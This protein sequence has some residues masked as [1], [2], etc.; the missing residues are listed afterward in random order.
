MSVKTHPIPEDRFGDYVAELNSI[1]SG[2]DLPHAACC[3]FLLGSGARIG[4]ALTVR[5]KDLFAADGSPLER[6]TRS[7]E[8]KRQ[9]DHRLTVTFPWEYLGAPLIAWRRWVQRHR[10]A[11]PDDYL[12][13]VGWSGRPLSRYSLR[14]G[15]VRILRRLGIPP[16]GVGL[17][18]IR[19][20]I[21]RQILQD[22]MAQGKSWLEAVKYCQDFATHERIDT[23]IRYLLDD[24]PTDNPAM[25]RRIFGGTAAQNGE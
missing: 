12:F 13:D 22:Q 9:G 5:V 14:R 24:Q 19:K 21:M 15:N 6:V 7:V 4:E 16:Q 2:T 8:K 17:H 3:A 23:T 18:G 11:G 20:T 25:M 1:T 10:A